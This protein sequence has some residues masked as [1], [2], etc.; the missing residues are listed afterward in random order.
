LVSAGS[1]VVVD[2][3]A[4]ALLDVAVLLALLELLVPDAGWL[5]EAVNWLWSCS[6]RFW[7]A[8]VVCELLSVGV[9]VLSRLAEVAASDDD[10]DVD[11]VAPAFT[12]PRCCFIPALDGLATLVLLDD[13]LDML[14]VISF[15]LLKDDNWHAHERFQ[16]YVTT[17]CTI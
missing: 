4:L 7:I 11:V 8:V 17:V 14:L 13:R 16:S 9:A 1:Y 10:A 12:P 2:D 3:T 15:S 5:S 6:S